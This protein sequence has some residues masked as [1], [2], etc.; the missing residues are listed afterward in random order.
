MPPPTGTVTFLFTDIEG[1]TGRWEAQP[2]DRRDALAAHDAVLR[3]AIEAHGGWLFKHTG[4]GV[5]AAF[6]S[7][8]NAVDAAVEAQRGLKLPVRMG[9]ATGEAELRDGDYFGPTLN[10][11][12]RM[13]AAG[14]GGQVL[15][16]TST[17]G[18]VDGVDLL[19]LGEHRLRDLSTPQRVYQVR[20]TGLRET[21]P[22]IR[23]L[24][25]H[26]N[27]LQSQLTSF[28][29]RER[30]IREISAVLATSRL[31]TLAGSGGTG[32]T[33]LAL[34]VA[35]EMLAE[36]PDGVWVVEL[37]ALTD[38]E[39]VPG[40][41]GTALG[42]QDD[43][44]RDPRDVLV[45]YLRDRQLLL[46]LDNCEH[47]IS[48]C[49]SLADALL[50]SSPGLRILATSRE[51]L[52]VA[53]ETTIRVPSLSLPAVTT[54]P[55]AAVA[56]SQYE[57][58]RLFVDRAWAA[59]ARFALTD[60]NA[61]AIAQVCFRLDGLPLA[62]ELAAARASALSV[63][64]IA[65]H[66]DDR[67]RLLTGGSR[68]ALPRQQ[69]LRAAVDWSYQL[70]TEGER[71]ILRRLSV[72]A[73][74]WSLEAAEAVCSGEQIER[75]D[76]LD[77][78]ARLVDRSLVVFDPE[79]EPRYRLLETVRQF[80]REKLLDSG[81]IEAA[82]DAHLGWYVEFAERAGIAVMVADA[83]PWFRR[84]ASEGENVRLAVEWARAAPDPPFAFLR[85]IAGFSFAWTL[86]RP[87]SRREG[88][89]WALEAA[90]RTRGA[91]EALRAGVL[92]VAGRVV[93]SGSHPGSGISLCREAVE[94]ARHAG[95]PV[96]L[97]NAL[98]ALGNALWRTEKFE[99]ARATMEETLDLL[100]SGASADVR[101]PC[102]SVLA[103]SG[104]SAV[105]GSVGDEVSQ[106]ARALEALETARG[107]HL[108]LTAALPLVSLAERARVRRDWHRAE[109]YY[110][111]AADLA[112]EFGYP[113]HVNRHNLACVARA[114]GDWKAA[115]RRLGE[116]FSLRRDL[117]VDRGQW[118]SVAVLAGIALL[119]GMP[120]A[121]ARALG[122]AQAHQEHVEPSE[123]MTQEQDRDELV[124]E[125]G[126]AA[127][128]QAYAEGQAMTEREALAFAMS[129]LDSLLQAADAGTE[130]RP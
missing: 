71:A 73:G 44:L 125:M 86:A 11:A 40:A 92:V 84:A 24:D 26:P 53:G 116:V 128:E 88:Q 76:V 62:I 63:D 41:V 99:E 1:S 2:S 117:G 121:G 34:Q 5:I 112:R 45:G 75:G 110:S 19:D 51:A 90:G 23:T 55:F 27:N 102:L 108:R 56:L 123:R 83:L 42:L 22:P 58:V 122:A 25:S 93:E 3:S 106:E 105:A 38:A 61:T 21:F 28:V 124:A 69:T 91:P 33:R 126:E 18:L 9:L 14:H 98:I 60:S 20:A 65:A 68:T 77:L 50:R 115:A 49:A 29:G 95:D 64:Q 72:F 89:Q 8:R 118:Y 79:P 87:V 109:A 43:P 6:S 7:A 57:A 10:R 66:L 127:F 74:G 129:L 31:V 12:S 80:A 35:A 46:L 15:V 70:L 4:D 100:A 120:D 67:F 36:F 111:E 48:V 81:E 54:E 97:G 103:L 113:D 82:R 114:L 107:H 104:L 16:A 78:L 59:D 130:A 94:S 32:K 17:A 85:L 30:E 47:L 52:G 96:L 119:A 39:G 13:E 101:A 37:A